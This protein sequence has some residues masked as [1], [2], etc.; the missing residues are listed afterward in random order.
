MADLNTALTFQPWRVRALFVAAGAYTTLTD[1]TLMREGVVTHRIAQVWG[2]DATTVELALDEPLLHDTPYVLGHTSSGVTVT[3]AFNASPQRAAPAAVTDQGD[4]EAEAF[5]RDTDWL[6]DALTA[7]RD[8]PEARGLSALK[9]DL[10]ALAVLNPGEL[11]HRPPAGVGLRQRVNGSSTEAALREAE[12]DVTAAYLND[13]RVRDVAVS[14]E[15]V[16]D[17]ALTRLRVNVLTP[18]LAGESIDF[19]VRV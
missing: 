14:V 13:D 12:A 2:I 5:G 4:A 10:A 8:L 9:H 17:K 19:I 11:V 18:Q 6:A 1:W 3:F 7:T 15:Q 16:P